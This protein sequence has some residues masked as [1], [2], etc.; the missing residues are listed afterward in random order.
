M[1]IVT[2]VTDKFGKRYEEELRAVSAFIRRKIALCGEKEERE[3]CEG[4]Y[5]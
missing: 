1:K 5:E 3:V 2:E 4:R